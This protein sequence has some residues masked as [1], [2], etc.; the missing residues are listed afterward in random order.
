MKDSWEALV[1]MSIVH[2]MIFPETIGGSGPIPQTVSRIVDDEF[3]SMI[4]ISHI[5]DAE[6]RKRV[7]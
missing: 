2:F 4:E 7:A 6:V 1:D 3:F 5:N